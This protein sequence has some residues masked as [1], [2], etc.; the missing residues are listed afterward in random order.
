MQTGN[1]ALD[2]FFNYVGGLNL[3]YGS[4]ASGKTTMCLVAAAHY[5]KQGKVF[6]IDTENSFSLERIEQIDPEVN[7]DNLFVIKAKHFEDQDNAIKKLIQLKDVTKL[8]IVDSISIYY[9]KM[10]QERQNV[11]P[12]LSKQLNLLKDLGR[13]GVPVLITAQVYSKMEGDVEVV[14]K[15]MIK[16]WCDVHVKLSNEQ[17]RVLKLEKHPDKE[18]LVLPFTIN[19]KG[20]VF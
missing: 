7:L 9:R 17:N 6:F 19:D 12:F 2:Q 1:I 11:N 3:I 14:G 5:S 4:P 8:V 13:E 18:E 15:N 20:L 16:N 10:L